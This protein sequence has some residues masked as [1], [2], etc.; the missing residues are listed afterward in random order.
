MKTGLVLEGG[1]M[2]GMFTAGVLD[3]LMEEKIEFSGAVGAS[4]GAVFGCNYKSGQIG[5]VIRYNTAYC[6]DPRYCSFRSLIKTGDLFGTDFC[7][8]ELP[9]HL[10][11][12]DQKAYMENPMEFHIVCTDCSTGKPIYRKC[13]R[14][15]EKDLDWMRGSAS[16]PLCA[17]VV[18]VDGYQLLDGG[19]SDSIPLRYFE[20]LGYQKNVVVLTRPRGYKKSP[21]RLIPLMKR[22]LRKFP[23]LIEVMENRHIAYNE[24][25]ADVFQK[26]K[27][28]SVFVICPPEKLPIGHIEHH[29][30]KLRAVYEIGRSE[31]KKHLEDLKSF[32]AQ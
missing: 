25:V 5:R 21:N 6:K 15:D 17:R 8:R 7:Y 9:M 13:E 31:A 19:I 10:D 24:T 22:V 26:E 16:M 11:V 12:F 2:R 18:E 20:G 4:A 28:G 14:A 1:A 3:V 32:L 29:A 23:R 27:E 30:E